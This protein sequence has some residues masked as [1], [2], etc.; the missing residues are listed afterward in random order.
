MNISPQTQQAILIL[1]A[2]V[3]T[4]R[5]GGNPRP[6]PTFDDPLFS[7]L[8][9]G[10]FVSLH[11]KGNH[12]LRGC[13]GLLQTGKPMREVLIS[14]AESVLADPEIPHATSNASRTPR[15]GNRSNT[16]RPNGKSKI[17]P[18]FRTAAKRNL[19][20]GEQPLRIISPPG[21]PRN[22]LDPPATSSPP[23]H[24]KTRPTRKRLGRPRCHPPHLHCRNHRPNP[25]DLENQKR[26]QPTSVGRSLST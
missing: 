2:D 25:I 15:T 14:A 11:R 21:R 3:V 17:T 24:R 8:T 9:A 12:A 4:R 5:L 26:G 22:R 6:L 10:C 18:G 19:S 13:V 20:H 16:P 23:M 1:T 7:A